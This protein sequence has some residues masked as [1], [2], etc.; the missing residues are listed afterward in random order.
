MSKLSATELAEEI[1][2]F[3]NGASDSQIDTLVKGMAK[4]H[5][6]LQQI[7]MK[8]CCKFIEAMANKPYTDARN[9]TSQKVAKGMIK[10]HKEAQIQEILDQ[11]N[12]EISDG[13]K[14]FIEEESIPS[15]SLPFI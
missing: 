6:T 15:K 12:G 3:V 8:L 9:E 14:K 11:Q 4:D 2:S 5:P 7:K 1:S 10:G 13:L